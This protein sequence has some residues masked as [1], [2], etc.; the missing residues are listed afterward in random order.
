MSIRFRD[1]GPP[2][3]N[4]D[5]DAAEARF[6]V[7]LPREYREFLLAQ[8]GGI[9]RPNSFQVTEGNETL[10]AQRIRVE[11]ERFFSIAP[12]G[13]FAQS[14]SSLDAAR[15]ALADSGIPGHLLSI[16][17]VDDGFSGG[18][19][20]VSL[21]PADE[22][23]I[24]YVAQDEDGEY[25]VYCVADS[26]TAL[27]ES[28]A[29]RKR[30]S[31]IWVTAIDDGDVEAVRQW[32]DGGGSLSETYKDVITPLDRAVQEGQLAVAKLLIERG[33]SVAE[34]Y[35]HAV[36]AGQADIL[37]YLISLPEGRRRAAS[38]DFTAFRHAPDFFRD[39]DLLRQLITHGAKINRTAGAD[40]APLHMVAATGTPETLRLFLDN[41]ARPNEWSEY[42]ELALHRAVFSATREEMLAKMKMLIDAGEDLHARA[43]LS[44]LS[45]RV[46]K[47]LERI[48][49]PNAMAHL[50][51]VSPELA[52]QLRSLKGESFESVLAQR[53]NAYLQQYQRTAA[54]V[55]T[56]TRQDIAALKELEDHAK[57]RSDWQST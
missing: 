44:A 32:L 18:V 50:N 34:A 28:M 2:L 48:Q 33:G 54:E 15:Q 9:P 13:R 29:K 46:R 3:T 31:P 51:S 53:G 12:S 10:P 14:P 47:T 38:E 45:E 57:R 17:A 6:G 42:G 21:A 30:K 5:L 16:A 25:A 4:D 27:F 40:Y 52:A 35:D 37:R 8:N 23:I 56:E 7:P 41:G 26:L 39:V 22:G 11:I 19:L 24:S 36:G 43:P 1:S 20:C 55:L 49:P